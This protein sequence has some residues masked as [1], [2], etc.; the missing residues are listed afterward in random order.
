MI[1][2]VLLLV[3][4][5]PGLSSKRIT[6][7]DIYLIVSLFFDSM[8]VFGGPMRVNFPYAR[9]LVFLVF[10]I[11]YFGTKMRNLGRWDKALLYPI[12]SFLLITLLFPILKG[13]SLDAVFREWIVYY[14]PMLILPIAFHYYSRAGDIRNLVS[15][16]GYF[17][18]AWVALVGMF[19]FL[20]IDSII[21][22][23]HLGS[24]SFGMSVI[25]FGDMARHGAISYMGMFLMVLPLAITIIRRQFRAIL[26]VCSMVVIVIL[27]IAL[28]RFSLIALALGMM[29][30][31]LSTKVR[32]RN[33]LGIIIVSLIFL[34]PLFF[35]DSFRSLMSDSYE[36]RKGSEK[37]SLEAIEGDL[38]FYEPLYVVQHTV[39]G[40]LSA[41]VIGRQ[42]DNIMDIES[43]EHSLSGRNI[44]NQYGQYILIYGFTGLILYLL[45]YFQIYRFTYKFK[46][47][48]QIRNMIDFRYWVTFQNLVIIFL[49]GGIPGG[50]GHVTYRGVVFI[51]AGGICGYFYKLYQKNLSHQAEQQAM[52]VN[53]E[54]QLRNTA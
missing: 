11:S 50:H 43:E 37:I 27:L 35:V 40:G 41:M 28:K 2:L 5:I 38:R 3:L 14:Y 49:L 22:S 25:F 29:N 42:K 44:H 46:Q 7:V 6:F 8:I 32:I 12:G 47:Y 19:T 23:G 1:F 45:I 13:A 34:V 18:I 36:Y 31:I 15:S 16:A 52:R 17:M 53:P 26:I 54:K 30:Y 10:S 21:P 33:R 20:K 39:A 24:R 9:A 48:L 51:F 4:L